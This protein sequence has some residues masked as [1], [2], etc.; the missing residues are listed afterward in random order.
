MTTY[1]TNNDIGDLPLLEPL[2]E[3][4][5][6]TMIGRYR[7]SVEYKH[8]T[9]GYYMRCMDTERPRNTMDHGPYTLEKCHAEINWR[10]EAAKEKQR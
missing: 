6:V 8:A 3:T 10:V 1:S 4:I 5:R 2:E 7:Y 9:N